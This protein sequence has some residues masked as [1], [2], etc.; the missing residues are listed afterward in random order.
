MGKFQ[1]EGEG[2]WCKIITDCEVSAIPKRNSPEKP[3]CM[4]CDKAQ[5]DTGAMVTLI[6]SRVVAEMH[7][8]PIGYTTLSGFENRPVRVRT[9]LVNLTFPNEVEIRTVEVAEAPLG[10]T[11]LLIGM[12]IIADGDFHYTCQEGRSYFSFETPY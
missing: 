2:K 5:W 11:D 7:L 8:S 10:V 9:Y 3:V 12:D 1:I 4:N 6:S